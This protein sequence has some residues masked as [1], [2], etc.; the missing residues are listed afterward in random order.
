MPTVTDA[1]WH[2]V[3][4]SSIHNLGV[5]A[6]RDIPKGTRILDYRGHKITKAESTRRGNAQLDESAVTGEGAVYLFVLNKRYDI[7]GNVP[8]NDARL[9]NHTCNP[10][11]EAQIIR[12][13][14]WLIALR[15]IPEG[16][17]L[18]FNYGF[19]LETWEDHPCRCGSKNCI[20]YIVG[21]EYWPRLRRLLKKRQAAA[22][23]LAAPDPEDEASQASASRKRALKGVGKKDKATSGK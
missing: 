22:A 20:G 1:P 11:C 4:Q 8:W 10:N 15:D 16:T 17:E 3:R 14:I 13:T 18:G 19:D 5:F 2:I 23:S 12:G 6:V 9:I 7:D 21:K